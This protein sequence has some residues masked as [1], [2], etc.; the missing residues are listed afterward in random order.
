V[1]VALWVA[2]GGVCDELGLCGIVFMTLSGSSV[3]TAPSPIGKFR[4]LFTLCSV[5]CL[6]PGMYGCVSLCFLCKYSVRDLHVPA[7]RLG[8]R[9]DA[10]ICGF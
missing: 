1:L 3:R 9:F 6:A 7:G 4:G 5:P 2:G 8:P 10:R